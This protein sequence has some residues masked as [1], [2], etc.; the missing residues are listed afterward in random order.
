VTRAIEANGPDQFRVRFADLA[1]TRRGEPVQIDPF[2]IAQAIALVMR[3]CTI[4]SAAGKP[5]VWNDYRLIMARADHER[6]RPLTA[7]LERDLQ[8]VLAQEAAA[9]KA[10]LVGALRV[11]VVADEADELAHAQAV[12]RTAFVPTAQLSAPR[13]GELTMRF[14]AWD[15]PKVPTPG[16]QTVFVDDRAAHTLRWAGGHAPLPA[17]TVIL[18][19]PHAEAP[20]NFIALTGAPPTVS[21]QHVFITLTDS[22]IKVGRFPKANPVH[23]NGELVEPGAEVEVALPAEISLS[24]GD[25]TIA[26]TT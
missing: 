23:V 20:N 11:T 16:S 8:A 10:E 3:E 15:A 17:T 9:R 2:L 19:R 1:K 22:G 26:V 6:I 14:D 13:A 18:G 12:V 4:R 7:A 25:L 24:R 5:L 21:K